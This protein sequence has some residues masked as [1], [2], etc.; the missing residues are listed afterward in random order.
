MEISFDTI[1]DENGS[2][3]IVK[4]REI[5]NENKLINDKGKV[6]QLDII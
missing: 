5:A 1:A 3:N 6:K 2:A 4:S